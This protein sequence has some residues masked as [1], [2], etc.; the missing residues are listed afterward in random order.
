MMDVNEPLSDRAIDLFEVH[1]THKAVR[2]MDANGRIARFTRALI[3][4]DT[5][6]PKRAF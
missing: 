6:L 4:I 2:T 3:G 1:L 5:E